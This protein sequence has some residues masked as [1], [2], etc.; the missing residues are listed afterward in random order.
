M[1]GRCPS[2]YY[3]YFHPPVQTGGIEIGRIISCPAFHNDVK[4]LL[5]YAIKPFWA[6]EIGIMIVVT[7]IEAI[8]RAENRGY[9]RKSVRK[10]IMRKMLKLSQTNKFLRGFTLVELLVVISIIALLLSILMPSLQKA[11]NQARLV[12]CAANIRQIGVAIGIYRASNEMCVPVVINGWATRNHDYVPAKNA[13]VSV[14]LRG[15]VGENDLP[16]EYNPNEAWVGVAGSAKV[17]KYTMEHMP[18]F[19]SCP[20][21]RNRKSTGWSGYKPAGTVVVGGQV[22][23][24]ST[25]EGVVESYDPWPFPIY[26]QENCQWLYSPDHPL[27]PPHGRPKFGAL[28]WNTLHKIRGG[29]VRREAN[30][31][32]ALANP[33]RWTIEDVRHVGG[34][35]SAEVSVLYCSSGE[36]DHYS[37]RDFWDN[38]KNYGAHP[39]NGNGGTNTLMAD[40]HVEWVR[41][42]QIGWAP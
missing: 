1:F 34:S 3:G 19:F 5:K 14:A 15:C 2:A 12:I 40:S 36:V 42:T 26:T 4:S 13:L 38:I 6:R 8:N 27:G 20:L 18:K 29:T 23:T 17:S 31:L 16:K 37:D 41:G 30:F 33:I 25:P 28:P 39:K 22:K 32:S 9:F 35:S 10:K 11:R 21:V 7:V 24:N